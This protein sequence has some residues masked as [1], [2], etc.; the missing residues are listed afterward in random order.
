MF[1]FFILAVQPLGIEN[2][3]GNISAGIWAVYREAVCCRKDQRLSGIWP[4]RK[5]TCAIRDYHKKALP[6]KR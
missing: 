5:S 6:V 3:A 4:A 2:C 1:D